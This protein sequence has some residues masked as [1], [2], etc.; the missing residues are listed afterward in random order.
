VDYLRFALVGLNGVLF[1]GIFVLSLRY[2]KRESSPRMIR[3]WTIVA[4]VSGALVVGAIQRVLVQASTLD[5]LPRSALESATTDWQLIQSTVVSILAVLAFTRVRDLAKTFAASERVAGSILDRV[6]H[7][8]L[9]AMD[10]SPRESEVLNLIG[11]GLLTDAE[12]SERSISRLR[13]FK[14]T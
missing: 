8:D 2:R 14:A 1:L 13:P 3:L 6:R 4:L 7:V 11:S 12:L 5:W 10:I 9:D